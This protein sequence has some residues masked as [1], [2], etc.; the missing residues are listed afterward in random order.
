MD[1]STPHN[2]RVMLV[3][4]KLS[5]IGVS[6]FFIEVIQELRKVVWPGREDVVRMTAIVIL[7][8][9]AI[10]AFVGGADF[11]F[12]KLLETFLAR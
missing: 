5:G 11:V 3:V 4:E 7:V 6:R 9:V 12:T 10:G 2:G 8:S 1:T